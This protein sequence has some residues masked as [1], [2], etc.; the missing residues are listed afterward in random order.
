MSCASERAVLISS[1]MITI[2]MN[3]RQFDPEIF[4]VVFDLYFLVQQVEIP[5]VDIV[6]PYLGGMLGIL[7]QLQRVLDD[8]Q[9]VL[10]VYG[11]VKRLIERNH[12]VLDAVFDEQLQREG[13]YPCTVNVFRDPVFEL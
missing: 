7:L 13:R 2:F 6:E 3:E 5:P 10:L 1:S 8:Q 9:A 4:L 12:I 11:N